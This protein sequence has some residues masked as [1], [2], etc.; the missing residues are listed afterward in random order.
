M[1]KL[2]NSRYR[3]VATIAGSDPSA[4]AGIQADLRTINATGAYAVTI[5]TAL[6][7]QNTRAIQAIQSVDADFVLQQ[8]LT[9]LNDIEIDSVK[10]GMVCSVEVIDVL[11]EVLQLFSPKMVI[12]DPVFQSSEGTIFLTDTVLTHYKTHLLPCATLITP[13]I[14]EA[15]QLLACE[16]HSTKQM[17]EAAS[18]LSQQYSSAILLKGGHLPDNPSASDVLYDYL[19]ARAHWFHAPWVNTPNTHGTGCTYSSA[20]A[21]YLAQDYSLIDAIQLAKDFLTQALLAGKECR[22]GAGNGPCLN[23][24]VYP[25]EIPPP[26]DNK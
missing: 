13:N 3:C 7:A 9:V 21:S 20:I 18:R 10:I 16:I 23:K 24:V 5:I 1:R 19:H 4:G 15:Q 11:V 17:E 14:P 26:A 22:L 25:Q 8:C 6:T 12:V 2:T